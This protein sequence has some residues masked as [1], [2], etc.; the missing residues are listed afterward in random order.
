MSDTP[1]IDHW[2]DGKRWEGTGERRSPVYDPATGD[3]AA[4]VRL[5]SAADVDTAVAAARAAFT[6]WRKGSL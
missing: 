4:E 1:S 3:V 2:I 5:A 6:D